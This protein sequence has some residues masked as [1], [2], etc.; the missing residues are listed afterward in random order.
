MKLSGSWWHTLRYA[1]A[2]H[3]KENEK[4]YELFLHC[5]QAKHARNELH[6]QKGGGIL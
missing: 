5:F 3:L 4:N 6:L 1:F 2:L